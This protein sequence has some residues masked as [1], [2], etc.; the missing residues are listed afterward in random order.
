MDTTTAAPSA[1]ALFADIPAV[2]ELAELGDRFVCWRWEPD[3]NGKPAKVLKRALTGSIQSAMSTKPATW[4]TYAE[5]CEAVATGHYAGI[6][7]VCRPAEDGIFVV[8]LDGCIDPGTGE[9]APW[10]SEIVEQIDSYTELSP[11]G[12]GLKIFARGS[13]DLQFPAKSTKAVDAPATSAKSPQIEI[14]AKKYTTLTG[15]H[16]GGTPQ[17]IEDASGYLDNMARWLAEDRAGFV[18]EHQP[19]SATPWTTELLLRA[20][21]KIPNTGAVGWDDWKALGMR[22]WAAT[23][24]SEDGFVAFDLLSQKHPDYDASETRQC[25]HQITNS[26][27]TSY[28]TNS[29]FKEARRYD[30]EFP[31]PALYGVDFS[32]MLAKLLAKPAE[33]FEY[34]LLRDIEPNLLSNDIVKGLI[35]RGAFIEVHAVAGGGKTAIVVDMMLHIADGREYRGRRVE[36][37]P[38]AFVAL[39]G[40][41]GIANRVLAARDHLGI[42]DA[43][44]ALV[45]ATDNFRDPK[46]SL[47]VAGVADALLRDF[48]GD[49][50]VIVLDTYTAA[51][52]SGGSDCDPKDVSAFIEAVKA[53]LLATGCTVIILHH[54][55]KDASRGGRGWSGLN[56]ALDVELEIDRDDDLRVMRIT[57]SRDGSD[58]QPAMC[59]RLI[60]VEIGTDNH[61]EP[62]TAVVVEHL[63]DEAENRPGKKLSP[64]ARSALNVLWECIKDRSRSFPLPEEPGKKCVML[65]TWE[66]ACAEPGAI[67]NLQRR[68]DRLRQFRD[69]KVELEAAERIIC[70]SF[71]GSRVRPA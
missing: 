20:A 33:A 19:A 6:G 60:G 21:D 36:R 10:A 29:L 31:D 9:V 51:L 12:T 67:G 57:K 40:H 32:E 56:A 24:G 2:V 38:V 18:R 61:G 30:P 64:K 59:Y 26:P 55:G 49:C 13:P 42:T 44:F 34:T 25:W 58:S 16:Y 63:A 71:Q 41:A 22:F 4:S 47:K 45:K 37:Q 46:A 69:A 28:D 54:F 5:A 1:Q 35:P 17:T 11:S 7:F 43:P 52:G 70:D 48:G 14:L 8:D 39:E 65:A 27:P 68:A 50:P 66:D 23:G 15:N 3:E 62:V 53:N